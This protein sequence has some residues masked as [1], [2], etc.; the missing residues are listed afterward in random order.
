MFINI[1]QLDYHVR[2]GTL[3]PWIL[4]ANVIAAN[5]ALLTSTKQADSIRF[6]RK[7][8]TALDFRRLL[9]PVEDDSNTTCTGL[10]LED[11][12]SSLVALSMEIADHEWN[13][14]VANAAYYAVKQKKLPSLLFAPM[15][16][17]STPQIS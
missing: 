14:S 4:G 10:Q 15:L 12:Q 5:K 16:F 2:S 6:A 13:A 3:V 8:V 1:N 17:L 7:R 9:M 11:V